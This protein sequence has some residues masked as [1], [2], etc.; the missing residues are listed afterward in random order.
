MFLPFI[1][2]EGLVVLVPLTIST[3]PDH[4]AALWLP[5]P[6]TICTG[7][8]VPGSDEGMH[9]DNIPMFLSCSR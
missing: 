9:A 3:V 2:V 6:W 7:V 1:D 4:L 5:V 8:L